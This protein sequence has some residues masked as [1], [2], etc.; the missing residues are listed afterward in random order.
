MKSNWNPDID[1]IEEI[2]RS[3]KM[4]PKEILTQ[5][6]ET[7]LKNTSENK[8]NQLKSELKF[9]NKE[10]LI[11]SK[12]IFE[13]STE[14]NVFD[15]SSGDADQDI[16]AKL[17][18]EIYK[19]NLVYQNDQ[20]QKQSHLNSETKLK[21]YSLV[22]KSRMS[23]VEILHLDRKSRI[24][25]V[26]NAHS[27]LENIRPEN[28]DYLDEIFEE[29]QNE[30][31]MEQL[32]QKVTIETVEYFDSIPEE[33]KI[34]SLKESN[35]VSFTNKNQLESDT[36]IPELIPINQVEI[37][38]RPNDKQ[39]FKKDRKIDVNKIKTDFMIN[40]QKTEE[41]EKLKRKKD[42]NSET[43]EVFADEDENG[44]LVFAARTFENA[45]TYR[46][47]AE[48]IDNSNPHIEDEE[49][50]V[51][52]DLPRNKR[53]KSVFSKKEIELEESMAPSPFFKNQNDNI[54]IN[55]EFNRSAINSNFLQKI[56]PLQKPQN[57]QV[58]KSDQRN[59]PALVDRAL[60]SFLIDNSGN[61]NNNGIGKN[62]IEKEHVPS[63]LKK[64]DSKPQLKEEKKKRD[65]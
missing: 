56:D 36:N 18:N 28:T 29:V 13:K 7:D 44:N 2:M 46:E 32:V 52:M 23:K 61:N 43:F 63:A 9:I 24:A 6:V 54:V 15:C 51:F 31:Y 1:Y 49:K 21:A 5:M 14:E 30:F 10:Q 8:S 3:T 19:E 12:R 62:N 11:G 33:I 58:D 39:N 35:I 37:E 42:S 57:K 50:D 41:I 20:S 22:N 27:D 38:N 47:N 53:T 59:L 34:G 4:I 25:E 17:F 16:K 45:Q 26:L 48:Q 40:K 65:F 64:K 60:V 55:N